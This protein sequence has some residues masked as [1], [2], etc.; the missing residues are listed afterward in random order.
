M[1]DLELCDTVLSVLIKGIEL[2]ESCYPNNNLEAEEYAIE[3][4]ELLLQVSVL[5]EPLLPE[6]HRTDVTRDIQHLLS[7]KLSQY[8]HDFHC[9]MIRG[10]GRPPLGIPEDQLRFLL[11][12]DFKIRYIVGIYYGIDLNHLVILT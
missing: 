4:A 6:E 1:S 9:T 8:E 12:N 2:I 3:G 5:L 7:E 11:E 10:C